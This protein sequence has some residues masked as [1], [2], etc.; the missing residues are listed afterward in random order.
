MATSNTSLR[1]RWIRHSSEANLVISKQSLFPTATA[2]VPD[3]LYQ[4]KAQD[5]PLLKEIHENLAMS[6]CSGQFSPQRRPSD[7]RWSTS[8]CQA[9]LFHICCSGTNLD[10]YGQHGLRC[11]FSGG[12]YS[13]HNA[14]S[15]SLKRALTSDQISAIP[16]PPGIFGKDKRRHEFMEE[17]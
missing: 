12:C 9:L 7:Q 4:Q 10:E 6:Q 2:S 17:R 15:Q 8:G 1:S 11:K 14:L 5:S 3:L 16:K 13:R